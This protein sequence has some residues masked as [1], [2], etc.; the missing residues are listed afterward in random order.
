MKKLIS[1]FFLWILSFNALHAYSALE[2][3][4]LSKTHPV[5]GTF[6]SYDFKNTPS[7][8][9]WAFT[10]SMGTSYQLQGNEATE[11]DLFG[12]KEVSI[13]TPKAAWA[14]FPLDVDGDG[15]VGKFEWILVGSSSE[16]VYKLSGIS[17]EGTFEY[18]DRIALHYSV[19][20]G[21]VTFSTQELPTPVAPTQDSGST[22]PKQATNVV[23][24]TMALIGTTSALTRSLGSLSTLAGAA[25]LRSRS[26]LRT[27][28][29]KSCSN[30]GAMTTDIDY[31]ELVAG[32]L[33]IS[34]N[35]KNCQEGPLLQNGR[36][37]LEG[38]IDLK[39]YSVSNLFATL[40]DF[41]VTVDGTS[42]S[43]TG[44]ITIDSA[45]AAELSMLID[46]TVE[47]VVD[48][49]SVQFEY[50]KYALVVKGHTI[51]INGGFSV[52]YTP[53]SCIDGSY[54]IETVTPLTLTD[55]GDI[56]SGSM[57]INT[58]LYTFHADGTVSTTI[59][60]ETIIIDSSDEL[61]MCS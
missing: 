26:A 33:D 55:S 16:A 48:G 29:T 38:N 24:T 44:T 42:S 60:G 59:N 2:D 11:D 18:S 5:A 31:N 58:Q 3:L 40:D 45:S 47:S 57:K 21:V 51:E 10:T 61:K 28:T 43:M 54:T 7:S 39:S 13:T 52:D 32:V 1:L 23:Q 8:F 15:S 20:N 6:G 22:T 49:K 17:E 30:G 12:W 34:V 19:A 25:S 9:D 50:K 46:A 41:T 53:D 36:L 35:Y 56:V 14:M 37:K 4:L 27:A